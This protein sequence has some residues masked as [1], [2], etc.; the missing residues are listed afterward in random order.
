MVQ[1]CTQL[2]TFVDHV[3]CTLLY[4]TWHV[5]F[6]TPSGLY[7]IV[8]HVDCT[9]RGLHTSVHHVGCT[10]LYITWTVHHADCTL[11]YT[12]STGM[13]TCVHHVDCSL[14]C[15]S[16]CRV[17]SFWMR[18]YSVSRW[19]LSRCRHQVTCGCQG[20]QGSRSGRALR[21]LTTSW[22]VYRDGRRSAA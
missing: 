7:T 13:Y 5:H 2:Y 19:L 6:C 10:L 1:T 9:P 15:D 3:A 16:G 20:H 17:N 21:P 22:G 12:T 4:T 18:R 11:L 8:H 14:S